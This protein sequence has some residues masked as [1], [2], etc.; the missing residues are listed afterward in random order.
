MS[1]SV[2]AGYF[3]GFLPSLALLAAIAWYAVLL[4]ES[5]ATR[6]LVRLQ[7]A[8]EERAAAAATA[9][10]TAVAAVTATATAATIAA[11]QTLAASTLPGP[12]NGEK[13]QG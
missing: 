6:K 1:L 7:I 4:F 5:R 12:S 13:A 11:V 3:A 10:V 8:A 9:A 2:I